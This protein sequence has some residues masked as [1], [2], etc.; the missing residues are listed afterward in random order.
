M[1]AW[2]PDEVAALLRSQGSA[3]SDHDEKSWRTSQL[4]DVLNAVQKES[5]DGLA[6]VVERLADGARDP[7]W[8]APLGES[9]FLEFVLSVAPGQESR[10]PLNKQALRLFGNACADCEENRARLVGSGRLFPFVLNCLEQDAL[11]PFAVAATLNVC[12]DY[13]PAQLQ[14]S[15]ARVS[16]VLVEIVTGERLS[17]S[18]SSLGHIMTILELLSNQDPEPKLANPKTPAL[19]LS[20][21]TSQRYEADLEAFMEICA[22]ALAYLTFQDLQTVFLEAGDLKLLQT[23]FFQLY[24][25]FDTADADPDTAAQLKQTLIDWLESPN[26]THLQTAACLSLGNLSRSDESSTALLSHVQEPLLDILSRAIPPAASEPPAPRSSVPPL[27]LIHASLSFLK[28]LA[29][30]AANKPLVGA[31]LLS[32][33]SPLLPRLWTSTRTQPQLQFAAVSLARLLLVNSPSNVT[34]ICTP[35]PVPSTDTDTDEAEKSNLLLLANT[36]SQADEDPIKMEA[37]RAISLVCRAL[38]SPSPSQPPILN[39]TWT[40]T[41][42]PSTTITTTT[43]TTALSR[44]H[45]AHESAIIPALTYL[46]TQPR[47]PTLRADT[48]FVLALMSRSPDGAR[49]ALRVLQPASPDKGATAAGW[50]ALAEAIAGP[51]GVA[52]AAGLL[53]GGSVEDV[54]GEEAEVEVEGVLAGMSGL[55]LAPQQADAP[56]QRPQPPAVAAKM[57]RENGMVLV[58]ELLH[59]FPDELSR[60]SRA[61]RAVLA[62]GGELV[63]QDRAQ[64]QQ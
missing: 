51:E 44:F 26:L 46:L 28:N 23:A 22:P 38:H 13:S 30:P 14:A 24:T 56:T 47:Y 10:P 33:P 53:G 32:P 7:A 3:G 42:N 50:R 18:Q 9:G 6:A 48:I 15:E 45:T 4:K 43:T 20:L 61:L 54:E 36:A 17:A 62:K 64:G 5:R 2:T 40:W 58:A 31:A 39:P 12:V 59:R 35:L 34:L 8:R 21:A 37:A 57:D 16:K 63:V 27:Q 25:R 60:L 1:M 29:I 19:L 41:R 55:A 52:I 49:L 11:L